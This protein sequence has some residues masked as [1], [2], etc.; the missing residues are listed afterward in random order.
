MEKA[1]ISV[2]AS[3][4]NIEKLR[5]MLGSVDYSN[6][7]LV[8]ALMAAEEDFKLLTNREDVPVL[9]NGLLL[10]M[11]A[12]HVNIQ[13]KEGLASQSYSNISENYLT[14]YNEGIKK[15]IG[16]FRRLKTL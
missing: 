5:L 11:A 10:Q 1:I 15:A 7:A 4:S 9:A 12:F 13:G 6:E 16:R 2:V 14:D 8:L 3:Y